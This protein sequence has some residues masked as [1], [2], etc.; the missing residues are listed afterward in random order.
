[1]LPYS[2]ALRA[3]VF[4]AR[5]S[6]ICSPGAVTA[7]STRDVFDASPRRCGSGTCNVRM[8]FALAA[9]QSATSDCTESL[10]IVASDTRYVRRRARV[11]TLSVEILVFDALMIAGG[12]LIG[13]LIGMTGV[14]AGSLTTPVLISG[15]GLQP[16]VAV[17]TDLLFASIT[18]G[19]AAWR[20]QRLA[21]IDWNILR[22]LAGG[23][24]PGAAA[25]LVYLYAA[26]PDTQSL[27]HTIRLSLGY[28]LL[29]SAL[30]NALYPWLV[31]HDILAAFH[32]R[33]MGGGRAA[34]ITLGAGL[35]SMVALTSVGAGAIGVVVLTILHPFMPARRLIGT[36]IVHAI[37]LTLLAGL[38]HLGMGSVDFKVLVLL[39]VGS[40][41]GIA[42]GSRITGTLPDWLLRIALAIVLVIAGILLL[43]R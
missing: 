9:A 20:H 3:V 15:F 12:A 8:G 4:A 41:P 18:K 37:P 33:N 10:S 42:A 14:G 19:T 27:A 31:R 29:A 32:M 23:S 43:I 17:G 39:L 40:I 16:A 21:N 34:T 1:M 36:D 26:H 35:G 13:F 28:S 6:A 22:W 25:V 2:P 5:R 7:G 30:A 38:G 24:L 11:G